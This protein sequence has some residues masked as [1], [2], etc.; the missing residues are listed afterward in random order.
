MGY[1]VIS[2]FF[3]RDSKVYVDPGQPCP[4][5]SSE[6]GARLVAAKCVQV[7]PEGTPPLDPKAS[8]RAAAP[9]KE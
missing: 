8:R 4:P 9:P 6:D 5:L 7:A 3:H 2:R 1:R